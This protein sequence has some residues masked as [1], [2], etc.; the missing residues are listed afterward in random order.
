MPRAKRACAWTRHRLPPIPLPLP[1]TH[2]VP[3]GRSPT[4]GRPR[5]AGMPWYT[6]AVRGA[7]A[8][9]RRRTARRV[10]PAGR[11]GGPCAARAPRWGIDIEIT[12]G[13]ER[14]RKVNGPWTREI[15]RL[16]ADGP[17][18][19]L[20]LRER[21]RVGGCAS[22]G[23]GPVAAGQPI[24]TVEHRRGQRED[25]RGRADTT[26]GLRGDRPWSAPPSRTFWSS[27]RLRT[28]PQASNERLNW[29]VW[30]RC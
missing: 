11:C 8:C 2:G 28:K 29:S 22:C 23:A 15:G 18:R 30:R 14:G 4:N 16:P 19:C 5:R 6:G 10:L 9:Y 1:R 17:L 3:G 24:D 25:D 12:T 21:R 26:S 13:I 7:G 27:A 20:G